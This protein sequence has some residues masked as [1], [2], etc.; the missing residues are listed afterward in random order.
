MRRVIDW[1]NENKN[2]RLFSET[3]I[4]IIWLKGSRFYGSI[5]LQ[6]S[7]QDSVKKILFIVNRR[8]KMGKHTGKCLC[9]DVTIQVSGEP[10]MQG[11][12]HCTDCK[13]NTGAAYATILFFK[14]EQVSFLSGETNSFQYS[15]DSGNKKTKEFCTKCG[16]LVYGINTGRPGIKS[17]YI[18]VLDDGSF[19][20]PQFNVYTTRALPFVPIDESLDNFEKARK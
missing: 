19:A 4:F 8:N 9:G 7:N 1:F 13:K 2:G 10:V 14:D 6:I 5:A 12:C 16:S 11:N 17:I 20:S 3:F 15:A 18:G